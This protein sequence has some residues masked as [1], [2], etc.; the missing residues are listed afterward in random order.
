[1]QDLLS[2]IEQLG[3]T[4]ELLAHHGLPE[5]DEAL[6]IGFP[7]LFEPKRWKAGF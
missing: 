7:H 4:P 6:T 2:W 1:M 5:S 3:I